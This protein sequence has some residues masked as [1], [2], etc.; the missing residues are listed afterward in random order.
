MDTMSS[1]EAELWALRDGLRIAAETNLR[2]I[3]IE[4]DARRMVLRI[5]ELNHCN[6]QGNARADLLANRDQD[7][8]RISHIL[9]T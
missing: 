5:S 4:L 9:Y 6:R 1:I 8:V 3:T 7:G 2:N